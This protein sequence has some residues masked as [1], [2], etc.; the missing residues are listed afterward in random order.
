MASTVPFVT[1][2]LFVT[3]IPLLP[4]LLVNFVPFVPFL[5]FAP[6]DTK[7]VDKSVT[8][9]GEHQIRHQICVDFLL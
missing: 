5:P 3:F 7:F 2:A 4:L 9:L 8:K 6:F 1:I